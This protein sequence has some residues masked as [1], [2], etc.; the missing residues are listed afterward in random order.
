MIESAK[1]AFDDYLRCPE[2]YDEVLVNGAT[3]NDFYRLVNMLISRATNETDS[4]FKISN[5]LASLEGIGFKVF[6][7]SKIR[8]IL[9][10][11]LGGVASIAFAFV[12][13]MITQ[14][15]WN[16]WKIVSTTSISILI[17]TLGVLSIVVV[18]ASDSVEGFISTHSNDNNEKPPVNNKQNINRTQQI[19]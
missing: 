4:N 17:L 10:L 11:L 16:Y 7:P 9:A 19:I 18:L 13:N 14:G 6:I 15:E 12:V 2:T 5:Q 8:S 3:A 1:K